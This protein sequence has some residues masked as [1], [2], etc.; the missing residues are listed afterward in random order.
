MEFSNKLSFYKIRFCYC[1]GKPFIHFTA[2]TEKLLLKWIR[3]F[4]FKIQLF[5]CIFNFA[6]ALI[7]FLLL[8][9]TCAAATEVVCSRNLNKPQLKLNTKKLP[10]SV[11]FFG[12]SMTIPNF[13]RLEPPLTISR[14]WDNKFE[15][16]LFLWATLMIQWLNLV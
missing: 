6:S 13:S 5:C 1:L 7:A 15:H 9:L 16:L 12:L 3:S 4:H 8:K 11:F 14:G 2:L 10:L